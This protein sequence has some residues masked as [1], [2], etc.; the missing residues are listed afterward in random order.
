MNRTTQKTIT[1]QHPFLLPCLGQPQPAGVYTVETEEEQLA[2]VTYPA[3]RRIGT[4]LFLHEVAGDD[5]ITGIANIDPEELEAALARDA[6]PSP[7]GD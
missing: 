5:R 3:Y 1:F 2:Q 6:L 4:F 7:D